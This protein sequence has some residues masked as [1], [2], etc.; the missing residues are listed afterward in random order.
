MVKPAGD[1]NFNPTETC[2]NLIAAGLDRIVLPSAL[3][4]SPAGCD[5][6]LLFDS[7]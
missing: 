3:L 2:S 5:L 4:L 1:D 7:R 6:Q